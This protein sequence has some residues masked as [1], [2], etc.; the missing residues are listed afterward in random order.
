MPQ[1]MRASSFLELPQL[2]WL[3]PC[4]RSLQMPLKTSP[5]DSKHPKTPS[6][7]FTTPDLVKNSRSYAFCHFSPLGLL[8]PVR[9]FAPLESESS[10]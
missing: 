8:S 3:K 10:L 2:Q 9:H 4:N 5:M 1:T 7:A 6:W